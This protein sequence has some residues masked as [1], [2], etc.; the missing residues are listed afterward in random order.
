[1]KE[2]FLKDLIAAKGAEQITLE[3]LRGL[4]ND[5]A[6]E[7]VSNVCSLF[8]RG[9]IK[10]IDKT[11]GK[12]FYIDVKDDSRI[13]D[14]GNVLCEELVY[15]KTS[16]YE[17]NGFMYSD[18]DILAIVS[19]SERKIYI[20]DFKILQKNYRKGEYKRIDHQYQY[21]V[22]FLCGLHQIK[23]WGALI[24]TLDY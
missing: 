19:K 5:Y 6:F 4:T 21:S 16:G 22:T 11:T 15:Y 12:E 23:S 1:M 3:V 10:V 7:D 13:A 2:Q 9:D 8:K 14:T 20:I 17:A 18:Y 24:T